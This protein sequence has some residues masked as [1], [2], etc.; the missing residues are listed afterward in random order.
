MRAI[1]AVV[2]GRVQGV[3]FRVST[4]EEASRLGLTGWVRNKRDGSVECF[5][6]GLE[7]SIDE[8]IRFLHKGPPA[9]RVDVVE[10]RD[11]EPD[12]SHDDFKV[13]Y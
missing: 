7:A 2:K 11:E 1:H 3:F 12:L 10:I 5:A 13:L 9:A 8:L 6:Q 4:R